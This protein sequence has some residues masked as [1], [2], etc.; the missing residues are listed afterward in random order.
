MLFSSIPFLYCFFPIFFICYYLSPSFMKNGVIVL[1]SL[2][3]YGW[4]EGRYV[5][6]M[7][8]VILLGYVYG[9]FLE[10]VEKPKKKKMIL[11]FAIISYLAILGYFKYTNFFMDNFSRLFSIKNPIG[12]ILLPIGISFYIFQIMSYNIDVYRNTC[13]AQK[14]PLIVAAYISLFP[15]LIAGPI[16]RYKDIEEQLLQRSHSFLKTYEGMKKFFIGLGK[17]ILLAN[18]LGEC[19]DIFRQRGEDSSLFFWLYAIAFLFHIYFDFSGYSDMAIGLAEMMG[20]RLMENFNY[21]YISRSIT[22]FWRRWHISL[23]TWFRD[24]VYIPLGGNRV[25]FSRWL[26]NIGIVW[27]LTGFWHGASW[28]FI[29]WGMY[30]AL[31]LMIEKLGLKKYLEKNRFFSHC[32]VLFFVM[33]SFLIFDGLSLKE[34]GRNFLGLFGVGC[35]TLVGA[36]SIYYLKN[37]LIVILVSVVFATPIGKLIVKKLLQKV[38]GKRYFI[39]AETAGMLLI[40]L[41]ATAYLVDGSFNPFLY[42][43]F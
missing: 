17:K 35:E 7:V 41:A 15:Q 10:R 32:Y 16:V 4:Q 8:A 28:N 13:K 37:F 33:V 39:L 43:R 34:A 5:L 1:F 42:F 11:I 31:F 12:T 19:C 27:F 2:V 40:L 26:F 24:Y 18:Q 3:F 9:V 36:E 25:T 21:P 23:G 20:F 38:F 22:E 14:N 29:L 30:F 6:L